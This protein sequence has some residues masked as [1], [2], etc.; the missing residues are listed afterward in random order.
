MG[1]PRRVYIYPPLDQDDDAAASPY[2]PPG[3]TGFP[4]APSNQTQSAS[5]GVPEGYLSQGGGLLG[6]LLRGMQEGGDRPDADSISDPAGV[7][8]GDSDN[9]GNSQVGLLDRLTAPQLQHAPYQPFAGNSQTSSQSKDPN[10]RQVSRAPIA[11]RAQSMMT[12]PNRFA[13]Q[14]RQSDFDAQPGRSLSDRMQ[15]YWDHP[16]PHGVISA[17][18]G[19]LTGIA[20]A[21]QGSIDATSA[22]STEEEAFRQKLGREQGPIGAWQALSLLSPRVPRGAGGIFARPLMDVMTNRG[23][24]LRVGEQIAT[25]GVKGVPSDAGTLSAIPGNARLP[26]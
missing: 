18:K 9:T 22:P 16:D 6:M 14:V 3:V 11:I 8:V 17:L 25:P 5:P 20:Q 24:P 13:Y 12:P 4:Q 2:W 21:V 7:A 23:L 26:A 10:F 1:N 15:A 19:G